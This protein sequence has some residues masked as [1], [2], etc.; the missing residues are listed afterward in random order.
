VKASDGKHYDIRDPKVEL[1]LPSMGRYGTEA[2]AAIFRSLGVN[3]IALPVADKEVLSLG[4]KNSSCKECVPYIVTTGSFLQYVWE[5]KA[6][7]DKITLFF[8]ATSDGPC[9]LGQYCRAIAQNIENLKIPNAAVFTLT[10]KNGYGGMGA[11]SLLKGWQSIIVS[12]VFSD[13]RSMLAVAARD[14]EQAL[15]TL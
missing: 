1:V 2:L 12:D 10:D 5:K 9:R 4:K 3:T 8:M 7:P 15:S 14:K 6:D 11:A 13:I